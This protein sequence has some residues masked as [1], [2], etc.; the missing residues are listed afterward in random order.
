MSHDLYQEVIIEEFSHP[1]HFGKLEDADLTLPGV[2]PSC[3]D[4]LM[5]Y[6][7]L[8]STKQKIVELKWDGEGCAIS[9]A[10]MSVLAQ[11]LNN[12][13]TAVQD[14]LKIQRKDLEEMLGLDEIVSGRVKCLM[15]GLHTLQTQPSPITIE[16]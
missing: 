13:K 11:K 16:K 8:D 9:M 3:G 14:I 12:E 15:L 1:H 7:K 5:L 10:A 4:A 2:N 6:I